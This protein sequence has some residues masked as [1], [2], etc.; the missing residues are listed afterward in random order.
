MKAF[1][2]MLKHSYDL[3]N[4]ID[5]FEL[6]PLPYQKTCITIG[7]FDGV[8]LGHQA[9]ISQMVQQANANGKPLIVIT[10]CPNPSDFFN[11]HIQSFYLS[12]PEEKEALLLSL[13]VDRVLTFKFDRDFANLT[14][15]EFLTGLKD[16]LALETLVVGEDFSLGKNR[17]GTIPVLRDIGEKL[18]FKLE[19]LPSVKLGSKDISSTKIRRL[20]DQGQVDEVADLLGRHYAISGVVTHGSDRG[21]RIGLP[22]ANITHWPKKKLPAIG[23]YATHVDLRGESYLGI[24]NVG[25][26]PTFE[27]QE[28]ANIETFIFDFNDD[29]YGE[30][31]KVSFIAKIRDEQKFLG[32]EAFLAQIERDKAAAKRIFTNDEE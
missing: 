22:T 12:T 5:Y 10:F 2:I 15:E 7:N 11:P 3:Q 32:V 30:E 26:R 14:P 9:I 28:I 27:N 17:Q 29:I 24:T 13:G 16:K 20:L 19:V 8:H 4:T 1:K 31:M 25:Y 23:V 6:T 18:S 21:A